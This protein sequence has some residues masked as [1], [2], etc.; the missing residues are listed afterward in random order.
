M[1]REPLLTVVV[2]SYDRPAYLR[3]ALASLVDQEPADREI[4]VVDNPSPACDEIARVVAGFPGVRLA[5]QAVNGGF[6]GGMN[7]GLALATGRYVLFTEDDIVLAPGA[8]AALLAQAATLGR[9]ALLTGVMLDLGTDRVR[10][11]GGEV[12]LGPPYRLRVIGAGEP[13]ARIATEPYEVSFAPGA[14]VLVDRALAAT[15]GRF[16]ADYFM[17]LEDVELC[18]RLRKAG[19]PIV[20]VPRSRVYHLAAA[21]AVAPA[22]LE[23]HK[24]KNLL[25]TYVLHGRAEAL[26]EV[27]LRYGVAETWRRLR[28]GPA[29]AWAFARAWIWVL[30]NAG[31]LW[32]E[33][34]RSA[35]VAAA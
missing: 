12:A 28:S 17:Y 8:I 16:R 15:T 23:Y 21:P 25:A 24:V 2:L 1:S 19:V 13:V 5:R 33:R 31:R 35:H 10:C 32:R 22:S 7:A 14:F 9:P 11:A 27:A 30:V 20:V 3:Q 34:S 26:P 18:L 6:T 4:I 29:A